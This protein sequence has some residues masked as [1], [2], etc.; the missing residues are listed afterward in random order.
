MRLLLVFSLAFINWDFS[1]AAQVYSDS[2][3]IYYKN[4]RDKTIKITSSGKDDSPILSSNNKIIAFIRT[5]HK[6]IPDA[7]AAFANNKSAFGNQ[8]WT[9]NLKEKK[10]KLLVDNNFE[11]DTPEKEIVDPANLQFS[12][13]NKI[14]YFITSA[15]V[16]S[17]AL[18]AVNID[19]TNQHYVIFAN[20][21]EIVL[22]GQYKGYLIVRQ[23]RY[24]IGGGSYDWW[25]LYTPQEKEE[26]PLG[27]EISAD[28]KEYL[29]KN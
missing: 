23:H 10:E 14:L 9:Y 29:E 1:F 3:N 20:S 21:F 28:Q 24:F 4:N 16:T 19:G 27:E 6:I 25:W 11:C 17:G 26:G 12:P 18:H 7:C 8:I 13:D 22:K 15:W 5:S 2:G